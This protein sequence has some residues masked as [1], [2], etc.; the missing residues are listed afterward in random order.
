MEAWR[1]AKAYLRNFDVDEET[2]ALNAI[3]KAGPGGSFLALKHTLKH[4][5]REIW[6]QYKPKILRYPFEASITEEA[7]MKVKE[8]PKTHRSDPLEEGVKRGVK[9][10]L[11][12]AEKDLKKKGV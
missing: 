3:K 5:E 9:K 1:I 6:T 8:I 2:L 4:F 7:R 11:R 10:R 12:E